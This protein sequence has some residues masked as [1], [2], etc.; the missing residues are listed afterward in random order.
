MKNLHKISAA[1]I[2][3]VLAG[4]ASGQMMTVDENLGVLGFGSYNLTGSTP[5]VAGGVAEAY[6]ASRD[7]TIY[8]TYIA[9]EYVYE[10]T[11]NQEARVR[12]TNNIPDIGA[13]HDYTILDALFTAAEALDTGIW[14]LAI[15]GLSWIDGDFGQSSA[16]FTG[17]YGPGTYY[18]AID[19][20]TGASGTAPFI[21]GAFDITIEIVDPAGAAPTVFTDLGEIGTSAA[22]TLFETCGSDFDTEIGVY[23]ATGN[24]VANNDDACGLQSR[25]TLGLPQGEYWFAVSGFNTTYDSTGWGVNVSPTSA[26]GFASGIA[27]SASFGPTF[28][29]SGEVEW[30]KFSIAD[31]GAPQPPVAMDLGIL[32]GSGSYDINSFGSDFDT[33]LGLYNSNGNLLANNDDA[34]GTLQSQVIQSLGE[35]VYYIALG[36]FNTVYSGL[37]GVTPGNASGNYILTV[38]GQ[39]ES[40]GFHASQTISWFSFEVSDSG[41]VDC[42]GDI[43]DDFGFTVADG[44][45]PD[46]VVDFGDFVA[47][48]GLIGPCAGGVPGCLGDI[49]DDFGF[50]VADGGGPDG[51]V[52]FGD[53]VALLGLIGPCAGGVPGCLGDIADDFGFTVADGGGP[54]GMV[55]FGDFVALL[56]LIGPCP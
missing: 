43:A 22:S 51:V 50:T 45:G 41:P 48:L 15:G 1:C 30:Y 26:S 37:F 19:E 42:L 4:S 39:I 52:D 20:W 32:G 38:N 56:G 33:E 40:S 49:A 47:L 36:G 12:L 53:F 8:R 55:D 31:G 46:G 27:G 18:I 44:G 7:G 5:G 23:D 34:G 16:F 17:T 28:I 29:G 9:Q 35:G 2:L 10:F 6:N 3:A 13:D 14:E 24:L 21:G 25:L 11:L 54:D